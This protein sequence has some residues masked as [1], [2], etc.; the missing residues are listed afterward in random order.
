MSAGR[1]LIKVAGN[2]VATIIALKWEVEFDS[3]RA[4]R[5]L[6]ESRAAHPETLR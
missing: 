3:A 4:D 5:V 6:Q 1:G 2:A